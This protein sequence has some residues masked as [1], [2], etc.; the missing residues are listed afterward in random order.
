MWVHNLQ[1]YGVGL[2]AWLILSSAEHR[3]GVILSLYNNV[4]NRGLEVPASLPHRALF[5]RPAIL[6]QAILARVFSTIDLSG[7]AIDL[8]SSRE[9]F[10]DGD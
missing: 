6:D 8:I 7:I 10:N 4:L 3:E 2:T 1:A 9:F 5:Q